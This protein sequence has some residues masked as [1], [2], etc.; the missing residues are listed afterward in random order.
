[1]NEPQAYNLKFISIRIVCPKTNTILLEVQRGV[2]FINDEPDWI[3]LDDVVSIF[4]DSYG[5]EEYKPLL[6]PQ[7][8]TAG[9]W[10]THSFDMGCPRLIWIF[11][12]T[13]RKGG[14]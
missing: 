2:D 4:L 8:H 11:P 3:H 5:I 14:S 13:K 1:M 9:G 10:V 12:D 7:P 6:N